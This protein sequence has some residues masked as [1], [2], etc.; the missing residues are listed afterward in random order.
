MS[1]FVQC[2]GV[3]NPKTVERFL[4]KVGEPDENGCRNWTASGVLWPDGT[5]KTAT[6]HG[7]PRRGRAGRAKVPAARFAWTLF[8]GEPGDQVVRHKCDNGRCVEVSHLELGTQ[9]DNVLDMVERH[10]NKQGGEG[11][12]GAKLTHGQAAE[13]YRLA[14]ERSLTQVQIGEMFGISQKQVSA[15]KTGRKRSH[16]VSKHAA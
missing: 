1:E 7:G 12:G 10:V 5:L 13:V 15:I 8:H 4:A 3:A 16:S 9:A 14:H 11:H 2:E 6:F